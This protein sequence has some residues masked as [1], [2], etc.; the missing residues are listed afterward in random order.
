MKNQALFSSKDKSQKLKCRLL[1]L[2]FG[3]L[4][5]KT[6]CKLSCPLHFSN[7]QM[8]QIFNDNKSNRNRNKSTTCECQCSAQLLLENSKSKK[9]E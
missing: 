6:S 9:G 3:P 5:I 8:R 1:Q 7:F 2:L 4:R